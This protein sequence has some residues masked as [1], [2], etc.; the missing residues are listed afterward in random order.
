MPAEGIELLVM[1]AGALAFAVVFVQPAVRTRPARP[2]TNATIAAPMTSQAS[3]S[4]P[5][6]EYGDATCTTF[7]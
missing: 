2:G 3:T 5:K 1:T 7:L 4:Q 6:Y